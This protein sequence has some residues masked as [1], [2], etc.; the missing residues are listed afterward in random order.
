M[1]KVDLKISNKKELLQNQSHKRADLQSSLIRK[2][3]STSRA[4]VVSQMMNWIERSKRRK[5]RRKKSRRDSKQRER[6]K[7]L[8]D[9][10]T[11]K[12]REMMLK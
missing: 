12:R 2:E 5:R 7:V 11:R 6:K 10:S 8:I 1:I 4:R 9:E 3:Q